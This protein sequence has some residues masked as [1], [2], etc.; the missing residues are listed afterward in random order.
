MGR[1]VTMNDY[2]GNNRVYTYTDDTSQ[3]QLS[4]ITAPGSKVWDFDYDGQHP[5]RHCEKRVFERRSNLV[6]AEVAAE[7]AS[8]RSQ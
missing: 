5:G 1:V 7:I 3:A 8:L 6:L 4:T 2:W